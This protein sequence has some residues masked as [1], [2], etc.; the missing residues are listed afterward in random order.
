LIMLVFIM[1]NVLKFV[2]DTITTCLLEFVHSLL[3]IFYYDDTLLDYQNY[4]LQ[5]LKKDI[6]F[7]TVLENLD[8]KKHLI[9]TNIH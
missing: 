6:V 2:V 4:Y 1:V 7:I 3:N 8:D 9:L 5:V